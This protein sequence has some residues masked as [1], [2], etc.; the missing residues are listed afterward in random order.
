MSINRQM[1]KQNEVHIHTHKYCHKKECNSDT[2]HN[3]NEPQE[4]TCWKKLDTKGHVVCNSTY[5]KY[6]E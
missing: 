4:H 6:V 5:M 3:V 1:N 2:C